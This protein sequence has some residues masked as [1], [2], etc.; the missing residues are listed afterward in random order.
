MAGA[1]LH[2]LGWLIDVVSVAVENRGL[3]AAQKSGGP[4]DLKSMLEATL[5]AK[6]GEDAMS[7]DTSDPRFALFIPWYP[8]KWTDA[9]RASQCLVVHA[10]GRVAFTVDS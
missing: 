9:Q 2:L 4:N 6:P 5:R 7:D 8:P 1:G 10:F 3:C